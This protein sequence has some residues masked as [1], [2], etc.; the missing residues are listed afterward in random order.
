VG[1]PRPLPND[2]TLAQMIDRYK[3]YLLEFSDAPWTLQRICEVLLEPHKQYT[4]LHKV[5]GG[6]A[7]GV[8]L[9]G[10]QLGGVQLPGWSLPGWPA[11]AA[12]AP[13]PALG[14][15]LAPAL[16]LGASGF[17]PA[18]ACARTTT[19]AA[20]TRTPRAQP[21]RP[22]RRWPSRSCCW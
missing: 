12:A 17:T 14:A 18:R 15:L 16:P 1:P 20:A 9:G 7:G 19:T 8:Q 4:R 6:P 22:C 13:S 10:V 3:G 5:V 11:S 21:P 2:E